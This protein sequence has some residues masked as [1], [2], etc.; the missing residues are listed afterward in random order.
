MTKSPRSSRPSQR[1]RSSAQAPVADVADV[2]DFVGAAQ[3]GPAVFDARVAVP[4]V[5]PQF[6]PDL[7]DKAGPSKQVANTESPDGPVYVQ[8][9]E[10]PPHKPVQQ[11]IKR[12]ADVV[13]SA[14]GL[15]VGAPFLAAVALAVKIDSP[16]PV[17]YRQTRVGKDGQPFEC[18][19]FRSMVVDA[20]KHGPRWARSFDSRVTRVGGILRRTS[21]DELPQLWNVLVGDMSLVGP[22]PERPVFVSRFRQQFLDYDLR[23]TVRPGVTGW[24]QVSG[25]RGNVS[26]ADR[27][28][29]D[30]W[31]VRNFSLAL[32]ARIL[33]KTVGAVLAGE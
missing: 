28:V 12:A 17:L 7:H 24:A 21:V 23:H 1:S 8:P 6:P 9:A 29:Y 10:R 26:I 14:G 2:A 15:W 19:K 22:R 16:G 5:D 27:T 30:V 31:Y 4:G 11:A 32:D 18:L 33:V 13:L 25:L 20:E 3:V